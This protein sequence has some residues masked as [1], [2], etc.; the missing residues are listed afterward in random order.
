MA[1]WLPPMGSVFHHGNRQDVR[2][3]GESPSLPRNCERPCFMARPMG[4]ARISARIVPPLRGRF[5]ET[6]GSEP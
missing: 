6:T 5:H 3:D 1:Y 2:E 4:W